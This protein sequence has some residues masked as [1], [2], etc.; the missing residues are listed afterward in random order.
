VTGSVPKTDALLIGFHST[1]HHGVFTHMGSDTH[2]HC[3]IEEPFVAGHVD[4]V[5]LPAGTMVGFPA[6]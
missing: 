2:I 1:A 5:V 6:P 4:H 3:I